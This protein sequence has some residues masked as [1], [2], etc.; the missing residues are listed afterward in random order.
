MKAFKARE[1][2]RIDGRRVKASPAS[3][4]LLLESVDVLAAVAQTGAASINKP[5]STQLDFTSEDSA[6]PTLSHAGQGNCSA[7]L[8]LAR[9]LSERA[10]VLEG[11]I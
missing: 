2:K 5:L 1:F 9:R 3:G 6:M 10:I 11:T 4:C 8:V 7:E